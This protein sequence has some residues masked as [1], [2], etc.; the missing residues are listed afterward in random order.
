MSDISESDAAAQLQERFVRWQ[1]ALRQSLGGHVA[2]IVALS[3]GGLA[4][5]GSILNDDHARIGGLTSIFIVGAGLLFLLSLLA[6]LFVSCLRLQDVRATLEILRHRREKAPADLIAD[7]QG[8]TEQLGRKTWCAV[9]WQL[10]FF[11]LAAIFFTAGIFL[12]FEHRWG[13]KDPAQTEVRGQH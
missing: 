13:G 6:A 8:Q 2:L 5:I 11:T 4:F 12:A 9:Y 3:S 7:L 10:G 1:E